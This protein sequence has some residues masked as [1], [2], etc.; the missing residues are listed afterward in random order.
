M[1]GGHFGST[2]Q[3]YDLQPQAKCKNQIYN[4]HIY[5]IYKYIINMYIYITYI[6]TYIDTYVTYV[7]LNVSP[8]S[9]QI[10]H[11]RHRR[12]AS[13]RAPGASAP[14]APRIRR[15]APGRSRRGWQAPRRRRVV[16]RSLKWNLLEWLGSSGCSY[17]L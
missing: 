2:F 12:C 14:G 1:S 10:S 5:I 16:R 17:G 15:S 6:Y 11:G 3:T 9:P 13:S 4:M 8:Q 7:D